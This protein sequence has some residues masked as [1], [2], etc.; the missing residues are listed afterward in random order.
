MKHKELKDR[1]V[2]ISGATGGIG[3]ALS[4]LLAERGCN[5]FLCGRK[6][7]QLTEICKT[8]SNKDVRCFSKTCDV[9]NEKEVEKTVEKAYKIYGKVDIAILTAGILMKNPLE[10]FSSK[11]IKES[12][13]INFFGNMYFFE[14][15]VPHMIKANSGTIAVVSTLA[16]QRGYAGWSAYQSS[17]A[18]LSIASECLRLEAKKHNIEVITIKPGNVSTPMIQNQKGMGIVSAEKAATIILQGIEQGREIISFPLHQVIP[19][20]ISDK[21]PAKFYDKIRS[22]F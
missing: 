8:L 3:K 9:A 22:L 16:D 21:L 20:R 18:A 10:K 19:V 12:M 1:V 17:K 6:E 15:L 7:E 4:T 14:H 2:L 11:I 5:L 13:M